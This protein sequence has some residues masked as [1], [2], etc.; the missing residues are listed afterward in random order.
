MI[1]SSIRR[2]NVDR[3]R[4]YYVRE[5]QAGSTRNKTVCV[6][7]KLWSLTV[8]SVDLTNYLML[9]IPST[10]LQYPGV[11]RLPTNHLMVIDRPSLSWPW[12]GLVRTF[13]STIVQS[14]NTYCRK[15]GH[16]PMTKETCFSIS[17][18]FMSIQHFKVCILRGF[19]SLLSYGYSVRPKWPSQLTAPCTSN[20]GS[21]RKDSEWNYGDACGL[22]LHITTTLV[23][24]VA[25]RDS[26]F[27]KCFQN[28][29]GVT[30]VL[31]NRFDVAV[32]RRKA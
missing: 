32:F 6:W 22:H 4:M 8:P 29:V 17:E 3:K 25:N 21:A 18:Q 11:S 19:D 16:L 30:I 20:V 9:H 10:S 13:V 31:Y 27:D 1:I 26:L 12:K 24:I 5:F 28:K 2:I 7:V 15:L 14:Y 23:D